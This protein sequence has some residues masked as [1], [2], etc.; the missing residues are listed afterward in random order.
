[1]RSILIDWMIEV[2]FKFKMRQE[3]LYMTVNLLDRYLS[4]RQVTRQ[5]FQLVG[6]ACI[7]IATKVEEIHQIRTKD[8]SYITDKAFSSQ[9]IVAQESSILQVLNFSLTGP[10]IYSFVNRL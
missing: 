1:M 5:H 7:L 2:L 8:L 6:V 4:Q 10:T 3:T 9:E